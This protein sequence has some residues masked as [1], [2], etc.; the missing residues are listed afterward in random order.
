MTATITKEDTMADKELY[1]SE[2]NLTDWYRRHEAERQA[3]HAEQRA[4]EA[5]F[6]GD[7]TAAEWWNAA[8][9]RARLHMC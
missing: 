3:D 8:A 6:R 7:V 4:A 2:E 5:Q 1:G 9:R